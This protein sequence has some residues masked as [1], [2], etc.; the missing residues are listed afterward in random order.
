MEG[1]VLLPLFLLQRV[2]NRE[3]QPG[4]HQQG[5]TISREVEALPGSS[6]RQQNTP[7]CILELLCGMYRI[8]AQGE[9]WIS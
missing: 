8:S 6:G 2:R 3:R 5:Y 4:D 7:R 1:R 9:Q